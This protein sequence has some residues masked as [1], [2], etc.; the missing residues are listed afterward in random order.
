MPRDWSSSLYLLTCTLQFLRNVLLP[1]RTSGR[2][3]PR[4]RVSGTTRPLPRSTC[5]IRHT[6][7]S[8]RTAQV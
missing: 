2:T 4:K 6:L 8:L 1:A 5:T 3:L 7:F